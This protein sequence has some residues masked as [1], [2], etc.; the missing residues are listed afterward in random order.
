M[1]GLGLLGAYDSGSDNS[2]ADQE[3]EERTTEPS[4]PSAPLINPFKSASSS[5]SS[6][7]S[8]R[9]PRPSFMTEQEPVAPVTSSSS[10]VFSNPFREKEEAKRAVLERHVAMTVRQEERRTIDGKKVCWNFRKGR[11]RFGHKCTFAHDSDVGLRRPGEDAASAPGPD[12]SAP[13][14]HGKMEAAKSLAPPVVVTS[15]VSPPQPSNY[16]E[17]RVISSGDSQVQH[18]AQTISTYTSMYCNKK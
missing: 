6:S 2:D 9:L 13:A 3:E 5:C 18:Y 7:S 15:P 16:D 12:F 10:S 4:L 8:L 11:C 17:G 1:S 14:G